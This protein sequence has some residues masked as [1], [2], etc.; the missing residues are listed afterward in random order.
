MIIN[1]SKDTDWNK[2]AE[3]LN[4]LLPGCTRPNALDA[5]IYLCRRFAAGELVVR[6]PERKPPS[7]AECA[8]MWALVPCGANHGNDV[9]TKRS[10]TGNCECPERPFADREM[11]RRGGT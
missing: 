6:V 3:T 4:T 7:D 9:C 8:A 11:K 1:M 2:V 10:E 5:A